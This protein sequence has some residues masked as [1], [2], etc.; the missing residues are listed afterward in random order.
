MSS[1][2]IVSPMQQPESS[3]RELTESLNVADLATLVATFRDLAAQV[4]LPRL[5][6]RILAEATRLTDWPDGS[7]LLLY[8]NGVASTCAR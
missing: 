2:T 6:S 4:H 5:L 3:L 1:H 8:E 7:V